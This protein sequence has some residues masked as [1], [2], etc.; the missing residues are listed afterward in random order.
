MGIPEPGFRVYKGI[1]DEDRCDAIIETFENSTI[2]KS[3]AGARHL[4]TIPEINSLANNINLL[5]I[6]SKEL[7]SDAIPFR[8]TLFAK[9]SSANWLTIW[10]QDTALPLKYHF[11]SAEWGPWKCPA[12]DSAQF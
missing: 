2:I 5:E 7:S 6:A 4:L 3:R 10:H 8:A 1:I 12:I 9:T 11:D